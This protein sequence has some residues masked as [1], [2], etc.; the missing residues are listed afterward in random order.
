[1]AELLR[2]ADIVSIHA[3]LNERTFDLL[4]YQRLQLMKPNAILLNLGR[5]NIVNEADL[6]R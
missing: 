4:N 3:P 2:T 1:M 5:G 6:A